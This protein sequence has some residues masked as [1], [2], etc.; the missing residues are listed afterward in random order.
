VAR[1]HDGRLTRLNRSGADGISGP[2][3]RDALEARIAIGALIRERLMHAGLDPAAAPALLLCEAAASRLAALGAREPRAAEPQTA[4]AT[5]DA[6]GFVAR[7]RE[8]IERR[9]ETGPPDL[10]AA[11]LAELFA[12]CLA[13]PD[14]A[15]LPDPAPAGIVE[16]RQNTQ[17]C[18]GS[19]Q[20]P[21]TH[22]NEDR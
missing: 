15:D 4:P 3:E 7:I 5:S 19:A 17:C 16:C 8:I 1:R 6:D 21:G 18:G 10:A 9:S 2:S 13:T 20:H 11:S 22:D 12:W 14:T